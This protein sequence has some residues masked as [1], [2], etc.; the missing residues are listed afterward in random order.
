MNTTK[1]DAYALNYTR[2]KA[3]QLIQSHGFPPADLEDLQQ[4]MLMDLF[5][6]L[7]KH[8][9]ARSPRN[10]FITLVVNNKVASLIRQRNS[11]SREVLR[12]EVSA[13]Q[14][15]D[16]DGRQVER[17]D[18]LEAP[19]ADPSR[20]AA[21]LADVQDAVAAMPPELRELWD[22]RVQ[23]LS[24][25]EISRRLKTPRP[26]LYDRWEKVIQHLRAR[27]IDGYFENR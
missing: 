20:A 22:L 3:I 7:Q 19:T 10:A 25:T 14:P 5:P 9:P 6:R 18:T 15:L 21:L 27:G 2:H 13:N 17:V 24:F 12:R 4:Q 26:T 11:P 1:V 23:D 16:G 8:D